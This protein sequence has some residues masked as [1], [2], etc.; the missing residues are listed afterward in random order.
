[1]TT[2]QAPDGFVFVPVQTGLNDK[3][4]IEIISGLQEGDEIQVPNLGA[5]SANNNMVVMGPGMGGG[6]AGPAMGGGG[7]RPAGGV[8]TGG[9][10]VRVGG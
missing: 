5:N 7:A 9:G 3:D 10:G 1:M 4:Y 6:M 2:R 8:Y